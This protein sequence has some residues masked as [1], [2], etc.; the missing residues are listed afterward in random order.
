MWG[1]KEESD[2]GWWTDAVDVRLWGCPPTTYSFFVQT[3]DRANGNAKGEDR[4]RPPWLGP[5]EA[6]PTRDPIN[7]TPPCLK[8]EESVGPIVKCRSTDSSKRKMRAKEIRKDHLVDDA[9]RSATH[10]NVRVADE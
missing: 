9:P 3:I 8:S 10:G 6:Q 7:A 1:G 5:R 2:G 4:S